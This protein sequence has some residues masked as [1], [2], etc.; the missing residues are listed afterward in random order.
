MEQHRSLIHFWSWLD[1]VVLFATMATGAALCW[2]GRAVAQ[3]MMVLPLLGLYEALI[4]VLLFTLALQPVPNYHYFTWYWITSIGENVLLA[5]LAIE[6]TC[7]LLPWKL[8][9]AAWCSALAV[10][11]LLS[12]GAAMPAHAEEKLLNASLCGDFVS[13]LALVLLLYFPGVKIPKPLQ[14]VI[15]A[16]LLT[17]GVHAIGTFSWMHGDLEPFTAAALPLSSLAGLVLMLAG[18]LTDGS[19]LRWLARN[20][21]VASDRHV[22]TRA[23]NSRTST[24]AL[25][26]RLATRYR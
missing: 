26:L 8:L 2:L 16:I 25:K 7:A 17:A 4:S 6:V 5:G 20:K 18:S 15:A 9:A 22:V 24:L 23:S 12:V 1:V 10:V 3:K 21:E 11:M 19:K 14:F 13:G